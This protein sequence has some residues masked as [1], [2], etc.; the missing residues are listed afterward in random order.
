LG[1]YP[2]S[3]VIATRVG[4]PKLQTASDPLLP[5]IKRAGAQLIIV[6]SSAQPQ[7]A[8]ADDEDVVWIQRPGATPYQLRQ[9]GYGAAEAPIIAVTEDHCIAASDFVEMHIKEHE[10]HP[11]AAAIF[12]MVDNASREHLV[13]W[14][15][16]GVGYLASA[17][18]DPGGQRNPSHANLSFKANT[19]HEVAATG[20]A[21]IEFRYLDRLRSAGY[22]VVPSDRLRVSHVQSTGLVTT[23]KLFF[24]NG[25][26][27][28]GVRRQRMSGTDWMR[29]L[30]PGLLAGYRTLR[31]I[32]IGRSKP[33]FR[34][35]LVRAAPFVALLHGLHASGESV[36]YFFGPGDSANFLH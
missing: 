21:V 24:N 2:I 14:A 19:L 6:D 27:I 16:Y 1:P 7:P 15:L 34:P 11:E 23:S 22:S 35:V 8:W 18:P 17:P 9:A 30:A 3:V 29:A 4:W 5:Q 33:A 31:T 28:A 10:R 32:R 13:D 20:D 26:Y 36:G 25:R 12:G